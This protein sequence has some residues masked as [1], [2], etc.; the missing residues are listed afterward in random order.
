MNKNVFQEIQTAIQ[1]YGKL[2]S[3]DDKKLGI[4][5]DVKLLPIAK[6]KL[7]ALLLMAMEKSKMENESIE[8]FKIAYLSLASFQPNVGNTPLFSTSDMEKIEEKIMDY[9]EIESDE[10]KK[11]VWNEVQDIISKNEKYLS[12]VNIVKE[13]TEKLQKELDALGY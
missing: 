12:Y 8:H 11:Y 13:E 7:K 9:E 5:N 2:L 4:V 3:D 1:E 6:S 10:V